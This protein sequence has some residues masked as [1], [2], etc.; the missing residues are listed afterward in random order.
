MEKLFKGFKVLITGGTRGIGWAIAEKMIYYGAETIVTG[1]KPEGR[2]PP[3]CLYESVDFSK[4][5]NIIKFAEKVKKMRVDILINNAGIN[6]INNFEKIELKDFEL[7][8]L[9]NLVAPFILCKAVI[10]YMKKRNWGRIVNICSI[11]GKIGKE[12]RVS[13]STSKFALDGMTVSL[14]AELAADNILANS[15]A[16]GII[17]T[18][19]TRSVLSGDEI[20]EILKNVPIKRLGKPEEVASFVC[21]LA[22]PENT[23]ISGQNIAIDG[24][25]SR[26]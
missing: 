5:Q 2:F 6:K 18:E 4:K 13:Y 20:K 19:L 17:E 25:F 23:F 22:S 1:T 21:W 8:Y 16:P 14:A 15:V 3:G 7:I 24:G 10:P 9:V 11:F 26:V 12:K